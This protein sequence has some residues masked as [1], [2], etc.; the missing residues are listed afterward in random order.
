MK[1]NTLQVMQAHRERIYGLL[2]T[3]AQRICDVI[4][5]D[6]TLCLIDKFGGTE[7]YIPYS[8]T[9][10]HALVQVVGLDNADLLVRTFG[11]YRMYISLC[12]NLR[13][14]LR[15]QAIFNAVLQKMEL[16]ERQSRAICA[17]AC[18]FG[19]TERTVYNIIATLRQQQS[20]DSLG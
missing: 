11:G 19:I 4:G 7:L 5:L 14:V 2:P 1:L 15:N 9:Q 6:A 12:E 17:T 8:I 10:S 16:G 13:L 3:S 18:E 20:K